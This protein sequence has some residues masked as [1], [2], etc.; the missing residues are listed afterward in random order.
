M[1][2]PAFRTAPPVTPVVNPPPRLPLPMSWPAPARPMGIVW[3]SSLSLAACVTALT[4]LSLAWLTATA[5]REQL[6]RSDRAE[7]VLY[8]LLEQL[9]GALRQTVAVPLI[10]FCVLGAALSVSL[11]RGGRLVRLAFSALGLVAAAWFVWWLRSPVAIAPVIHILLSVA[12]AW[13]PASTR[14]LRRPRNR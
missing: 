4:A 13:S 1:I 2:H 14:W 8:Q 3:A 11:I 7:A 12:L 9:E 6:D 5:G 10:F